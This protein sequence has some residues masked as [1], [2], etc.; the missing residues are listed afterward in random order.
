VKSTSSLAAK[1]VG[2]ASLALLL[3]TSVFAAPQDY[4]RRDRDARS[5]YR[6]DRISTQGH[7]REIRR[8][9][10]RFRITLD[11]G[12]YPYYVPLSIVRNRNLRIGDEVRLG[13]IVAGDLVTVDLLAFRGDPYFGADPNYRVVPRGSSG[14]MS[15]VVQRVDRHLGYLVIRDDA[16]GENVKI[17][18]RHMNMR[19]PVNVWGIRAGEHIT[20]NGSWENRD[21]FDALRLEY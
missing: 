4:H 2:S 18:V 1:I 17:D 7:I 20:I 3:G 13:G 16:G 19:R 8:E 9:G 6:S 21:T 10:D 11:R 15:G 5:D 14:W 12:S